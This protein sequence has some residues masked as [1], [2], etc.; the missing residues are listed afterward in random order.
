[1]YDEIQQPGR[2]YVTGTMELLLEEAYNQG[3]VLFN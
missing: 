2:H 1:M 3:A